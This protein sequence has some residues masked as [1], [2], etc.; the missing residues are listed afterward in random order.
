MP[1][2]DVSLSDLQVCEE[3]MVTINHQSLLRVVQAIVEAVGTSPAN[4][5]IVGQSLVEA[6]LQGHDSHGVIRLPTYLD[7]VQRGSV[8][9]AAIAQVHLRKG[10]TAQ[11]DGGRGWGQPA[12][13][14]AT[15]TA[16]GLAAEH[17]IGAVSIINGNHIGRVGEYVEL[18]ANAGMVGIA[19]CNAGPAVAPYGGYQR[20]MGTNP[21]AWA[22]PGGPAQAPFVLDFATSGVAEGKLR[23]ARST[24]SQIADGLVVDATGR[25]SRDPA[26]FYAGGALQAFGLHKGSGLS[27]MIELLAR[28]LCGVDPTR[29]QNVEQNGTLILA[30]D[31]AT[32]A[33]EEQFLGAAERMRAQFADLSPSEGFDE[34][35][36]PGDF[37]QRTR[38]RRLEEGIP[39]PEQTW[40][41][42]QALAAHWDVA[43]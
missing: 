21:L 30:L 10:A 39:M 38:Q 31:I 12:A 26:D 8:L 4:A 3:R 2:L 14:L 19:F 16:I 34:V 24:G 9:P 40:Q 20:V 5:Q 27:V 7:F 11:V 28:G 15:E 41:A 25:P 32:F 23:V 29:S 42:I 37:E 18:I 35:L 6:N 1:K 36:L 43:L 33:P 17:G 13:R 22:A